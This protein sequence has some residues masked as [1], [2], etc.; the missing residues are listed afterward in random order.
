MVERHKLVTLT[1]HRGLVLNEVV[2]LGGSEEESVSPQPFPIAA[3]QERAQLDATQ[4]YF[5]DWLRLGT[6]LAKM[7]FAGRSAGQECGSLRAIALT[8]DNDIHVTWFHG[9]FPEETI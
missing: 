3:K 8:T 6:G 7:L 1:R 9:N 5:E 2:P 4:T